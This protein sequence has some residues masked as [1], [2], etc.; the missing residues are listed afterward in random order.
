[1]KK[2]AI[3]N[4]KHA[5]YGQKAEEAL[6]RVGAWEAVETKIV[7]G[8]NIAQAAQFAFTGAADVGIVALS[9]A[10]SPEM[11]A[12]GKYALVPDSLHKPLEQGFVVT[13]RA[14]DKK[15]AAEFSGW[16]ADKTV[17]ATMAKYGFA[18]PRES[19]GK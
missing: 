1:V 19:T 8:E 13:N 6:R 14:K 4:P 9:L 7:F 15:L 11:A 5:P 10:L 18:L 12:K 3:A 2:V 17:R 16:M